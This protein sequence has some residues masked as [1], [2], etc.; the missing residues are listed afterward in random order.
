MSIASPAVE[1]EGGPLAPRVHV[2]IVVALPGV[3]VVVEDE[4]ALEEDALWPH[5]AAQARPLA[6]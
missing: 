2:V 4:M 5:F 6:L 3:V 1:A